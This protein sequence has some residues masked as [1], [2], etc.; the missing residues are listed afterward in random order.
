M[1]KKRDAEYYKGR[2]AK[3]YPALRAKVRSGELSTRA[4]SA[5]AGLIRLP[6]RL[7][8]LQREW[9]KASDAQRARFLIWL[10]SGAYKWIG[11]PIADSEGRLRRDVSDYLL[12]WVARKGVKPG[13]VM[14]A[15]GFSEYDPTFLSAISSD[16]QLRAEVIPKLAAWLK[17]QGFR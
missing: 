6:T 7:D 16:G 17:K 12:R 13:F 14:K 15:I 9:K 10:K 1:K 11:L 4:A 3:G 8:A 2:L 5:K